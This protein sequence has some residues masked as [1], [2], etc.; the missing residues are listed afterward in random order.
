MSPPED[1]T[2]KDAA[3]LGAE[4]GIA[5]STSN[6]ADGVIMEKDRP[7][8]QVQEGQP[9]KQLPSPPPREG[10]FAWLQVV[11]A[12]ALNLNTW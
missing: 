5:H 11:G 8:A 12:F 3:E 7:P 1:L 9:Q 2:S 4:A 10:L 6:K